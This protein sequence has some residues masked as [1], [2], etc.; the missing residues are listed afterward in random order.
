MH[1]EQKNSSEDDLENSIL[2]PA[3]ETSSESKYLLRLYVA[4]MSNRSL[5]AIN[6]IKKM[7]EERIKGG[8]VLEIIDIYQQPIMARN[9]QILATPTLVKELPEPLR[10][11]IGDL[12]NEKQLLLGL[13]L[14]DE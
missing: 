9:G 10:K 8:V 4:G 6:Q 14:R 5:K 3:E 13:D 11:I 12:S 7:C 2:S 1:E